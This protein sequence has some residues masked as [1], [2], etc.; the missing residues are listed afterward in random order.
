MLMSFNDYQNKSIL[1]SRRK[2]KIIHKVLNYLNVKN[3]MFLDGQDPYIYVKSLYNRSDVLGIRIYPIAN[4][5][6]FKIQDSYKS[7][8]QGKPH[9]LDFEKVY[10]EII[11]N[12]SRNKSVKKNTEGMEET[13]GMEG[14]EGMEE[15]NSEEKA[16]SKVAKQFLETLK[17]FF[18]TKLPTQEKEKAAT[19]NLGTDYSSSI[20]SKY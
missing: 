8:P 10:G 6:A 2:I 11:D 9:L 3:K 17:K 16:A 14:V 19:I 1:E 7:L 20:Y 4:K 15:D 5:I 12:Y 18:K 13:E